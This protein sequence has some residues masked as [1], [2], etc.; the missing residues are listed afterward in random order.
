MEIGKQVGLPD[1][2][3]RLPNQVARLYEI[4]DT[5]IVSLV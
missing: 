1:D 2:G 4:H 3:E 5:L